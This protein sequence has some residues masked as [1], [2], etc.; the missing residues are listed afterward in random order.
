MYFTP[1]RSL[2]DMMQKREPPA[3]RLEN[4]TKTFPGTVAVDEVDFDVHTAEVHAL[5]G[6]NGAGKST[7]MKILAGSY[8][9]YDGQMY[10]GGEEVRMTSP[11]MAKQHGIGMVY[12]EN[13]LARSISVAENLLAGRLPS[14]GLLIDRDE[15]RS[16][17]EADLERVG[18]GNVDP[19]QPVEELSQ[20]EAKLV[21]IARVLGDEPDIL[22]MD[23]PTPMLSREEVDRLFE[24]IDRLRE[25]GLAIVY[26]SHHLPEIFRVA[27]RV[28]VLR[29]G[30]RITTED[31]DEV[32]EEQLVRWMVGGKVDVYEKQ[33]RAGG[34]DEQFRVD[35]VSRYGFFHDVSFRAE[36]GEVVGIAGLSGS[37][38]TDLGR[39][40]C[41]LD[42][43]DE[44]RVEVDGS[45]VTPRSFL[46]AVKHGL[47]Y[48]S[49]DR[50]EKGLFLDLTLSENLVAGTLPDYC[51][52]EFF[53]DQWTHETVETLTEE[54]AIDP[55]DPSKQ[56][57]Q[58]SG[59]NQQKALMGKWLAAEPEV[60]VLNHPTQ[61]VDVG[62]KEFLH[63]KILELAERGKTV[64]LISSDLPEF[65]RL[66]D[67]AVVMRHGHRI[68]RIP[69][70]ELSEEN[71][72]LAANGNE[73]VMV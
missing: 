39:S 21:E 11:A 54:L 5:I 53:L 35:Q 33:E 14:N 10:I 27:D 73:E 65:V 68:G 23:E 30:Q 36:E 48:L 57:K 55:P 18:L 50:K 24:I 37:G 71:I 49:E 45:D 43:L 47:V 42:P 15:V 20:H 51:R 52:M 60:L 34:G 38:R 32:T 40:I 44:G 70:E 66:C 13:I 56:M 41:G 25:R 9:E 6:E 16:A 22:V 7:L 67:R 29:D 2:D 59:G 58:F 64:I 69:G 62:A 12:Q 17:A 19:S 63:Q 8:P 26:I 72:L 31:T 3:I 28:T 1:N 61:G 46:D 4:V